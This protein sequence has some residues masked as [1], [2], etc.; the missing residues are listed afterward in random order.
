MMVNLDDFRQAAQRVLPRFV[1][2]YVAG[3]ADDEL[4]L[5]R[6]RSDLESMTLMPRSL[7]DTTAASTH[8]QVFGRTWSAP[9]GV[10]PVGLI[11]VVRPQ[12]DTL[13]ARAAGKAGLPY[14]LS[15]ASN[16]RL[17]EVRQATDGPCWMQLYVMQ[18]RSMAD[19]ILARAREAGFE[20]LVLTVDVPVGGYRE[21]DLRHGFKLPFRPGPRVLLDMALHPNWLRRQA[22]AGAPQFVNLVPAGGAGSTQAQAALLSRT[23]DRALVWEDLNWLR[24]NWDGPVL[25]KG[26]LHPE[27]ARLALHAGVDGLIVSNHG[28]RQL[29]TAPSSVAVLPSILDVVQ[30]RLP[31]FVDSGFRRG[32]D[33]AKALA[34]GAQ[35]VFMGRPVAYGLAQG[36]EQ[37]VAQVLDL[38]RQE[39]LRTM[40]LLGANRPETLAD[41]LPVPMRGQGA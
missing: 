28:G 36:G 22:W 14:I 29:D 8:I 20:A 15:T 2:D 6:N 19:T 11:D 10:A 18:D 31:V 24:S 26:V 40:I 33:V 35:G 38:V 41:C 27:D 9:F 3:G 30:S 17:E 25:I 1:Y 32:S 23:M 4:C 5:Q 13:A 12:G 39:L 34:L 21:K 7:R 37:G 16:S